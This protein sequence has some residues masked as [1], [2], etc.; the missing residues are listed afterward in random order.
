[1]K[2]F[3]ILTTENGSREDCSVFYSNFL[4]VSNDANPA[5]NFDEPLFD[6]ES[7]EL[8]QL[9]DDDEWCEANGISD[10]EKYP[11]FD[12]RWQDAIKAYGYEIEVPSDPL[13]I[14][15]T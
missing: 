6:M 5:L 15:T 7:S 11:S 10:T 1:M 12:T 13:F 14:V 9:A 8:L 2:K 4:F 3:V